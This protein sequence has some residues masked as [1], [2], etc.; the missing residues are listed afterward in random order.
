MNIKIIVATHKKYDMPK[1][2]MYLPLHVGAKGKEKLGYTTD[3]TKN[4]CFIF[5]RFMIN[6]YIYYGV[7]RTF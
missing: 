4:K 2:K 6:Y 7:V 5:D 1:D 3:D